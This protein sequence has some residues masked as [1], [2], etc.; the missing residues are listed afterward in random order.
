M[1][2]LFPEDILEEA[3]EDSEEDFTSLLTVQSATETIM[4][5]P[6][7]G[8][9]S[10]A[11]NLKKNK[12][13]LS[14]RTK[15]LRGIAS[16]RHNH[17]SN[18]RLAKIG[19]PTNLKET[20]YS[21]RRKP[22]MSETT[23]SL[24][25]SEAG[26]EISILNNRNN[27]FWVE[28]TVFVI[29]ES[30][31]D[32]IQELASDMTNLNF[33]V[34]TESRANGNQVLRMMRTSQDGNTEKLEFFIYCT[35]EVGKSVQVYYMSN[36]SLGTLNA[37]NMV[38]ATYLYEDKAEEGV[39]GIFL[40]YKTFDVPRNQVVSAHFHRTNKDFEYNKTTLYPKIDI[41]S[42]V[43]L[44]IESNENILLL[45]GSPGVGKTSLVKILL[46]CLAE[47]KKDDIKCC[48]VKDHAVL[49]E[50]S[51][52]TLMTQQVFDVL[53]LDDLDDE[54][55]PRTV[56]RNEGIVNKLLS[57]SDGLFDTPTKI[58]ITTNLADSGI[59]PAIV[60]PGRCFDA[61]KIPPLTHDEAKE[62]WVNE[63]DMTPDQWTNEG[64]FDEDMEFVT[65][66]LLV[67]EVERILAIS[68]KDYL[69]DQS[70]SVRTKY[71]KSRD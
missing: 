52:W 55:L 19:Q 24:V 17:R 69:R 4:Y 8:S 49:R 29:A 33:T 61:L 56:D 11:T 54:L 38:F 22:A 10:S 58:V 50:D 2:E 15:A 51:F 64:C 57:F 66:A 63:Y 18:R 67:S 27:L 53:I 42:M 1:G 71:E 28:N 68:S 44:Y 25:T 3:V 62:I 23:A 20:P 70:I 41:E 30:V 40:D 5:T 35:E 26:S 9:L 48:Y 60:R 12:R 65:Q 7:K 34:T 59:D 46:R 37:M 36:I 43:A 13:T 31:L 32:F 14:I 6:A 47:N 39:Y 16:G 45:Q 21:I